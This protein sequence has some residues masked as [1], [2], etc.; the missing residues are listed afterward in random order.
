[1]NGFQ[2]KLIKGDGVVC[3]SVIDGTKHYV[4]E[5]SSIEDPRG[6]KSPY[7]HDKRY[8]R[9]SIINKLRDKYEREHILG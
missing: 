2:L 3:V 9:Y 5:S 8:K 4:D 7:Y 6:K 1:M